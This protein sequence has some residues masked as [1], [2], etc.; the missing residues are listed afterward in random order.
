MKYGTYLE[1]LS[2]L[3]MAVGR[4][5]PRYQM[6]GVIYPRSKRLLTQ[7]FEYFIVVVQLCHHALKFSQKK[8]LGQFA[9]SLSDSDLGSYQSQLDN[10]A[11]S[12]KEE[13][14]VLMAKSVEDERDENSRFRALSSKF[15]QSAAYHQKLKARQQVLNACSTYDHVTTWKQ[16]RKIGSTV[17][18]EQ[19]SAYQ[20]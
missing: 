19:N 7:L 12:I 14:N 13:V 11:N 9:S 17:L 15:N 4:S 16:A 2:A 1:K 8:A 3:L 18:F 6:I 5:A 10:W 20:E